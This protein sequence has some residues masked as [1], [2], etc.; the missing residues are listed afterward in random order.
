L[1]SRL[2][3]QN[4]GVDLTTQKVSSLSVLSLAILPLFYKTKKKE[5]IPFTTETRNKVFEKQDHKCAICG[6]SLTRFSINFDHI[7]GNRSDN[8]TSNCSN[9]A[10][11]HH[12]KKEFSAPKIAFQTGQKPAGGT[13]EYAIC[14]CP[15]CD[16]CFGVIAL[17]CK[18]PALSRSCT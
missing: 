13:F 7:N 11:K 18:C 9:K 14:S 10:S 15:N 4:T 5:N 1:D 8:R 16:K 12:S 3:C 2:T 6:K 17:P